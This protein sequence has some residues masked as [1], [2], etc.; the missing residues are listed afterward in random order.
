M[1]ALSAADEFFVLF[2]GASSGGDSRLEGLRFLPLRETPGSAM[3]CCVRKRNKIKKLI[4][5]QV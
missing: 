5:G 4:L 2:P 3:L 1:L